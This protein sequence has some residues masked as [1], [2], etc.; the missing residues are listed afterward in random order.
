MKALIPDDM[1]K[2]LNLLQQR[3]FAKGI[4]TL[5]IFEGSSGRVI[6]RVVNEIMR[7]LE[8]R[9]VKYRHFD[10]TLNNGPQSMVDFLYNTPAKGELGLFDRSWYSRV[11]DRYDPD[12]DNMPETLKV[13]NTFEKYLVDN[14]IFL[15]KVLLKASPEVLE[16][17]GDEYWPPAGKKTFLNVDK[18]D[19]VKF[20]TVMLD[21]VLENSN[22]TIAPWDYIVVGDVQKTVICAVEAVCERLD[23]RLAHPPKYVKVKTSS[24]CPNPRKGLNLDKDCDD[25]KT[26]LDDLSE[27]LHELQMELA[28]SERSLVLC[29]EGWDAAGKGSVIKHVTHALNPRGYTVSQTKA[30]TE[31]ELSH[32]YLWRFCGSTPKD[33]HITIYDRTWYGRM[34]VEPIEGLCSDEEYE[35]APS[36]INNFED[37]MVRNVAIVMKFWFDISS[38]VQLERFEERSKDPLKVWKITDEDWRNRDKWDEYDRYVNKM[39]DITSTKNAPWIVIESNNKKYARVKVIQ[40]IV[41]RLKKELSK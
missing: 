16:R 12:N 34:M 1:A 27:E 18:V 28:L 14:G 40:T 36:E 33:G 35:R 39:M 4:P 31:V 11:I 29:F 2:E 20:R 21:D 23:Q 8:P 32:P 41:D 24:K 22:T 7:C 37:I 38:D 15:I 30:P 3:A 26:K 5:I 10:P 6:G 17:Y 19:P 13:V 9:G 25:Y